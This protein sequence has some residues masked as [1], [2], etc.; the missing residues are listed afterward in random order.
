MQQREDRRAWRPV[1]IVKPA[2]TTARCKAK[3]SPRELVSHFRYN[4]GVP[5]LA[6]TSLLI[7]LFAGIVV[8][9]AT[10]PIL[11]LIAVGYWMVAAGL[12]A[13]VPGG[14]GYHVWMYRGLKNMNVGAWWW[15]PGAGPAI[16]E[17]H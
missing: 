13:G 17:A 10:V 15:S 9:T 6:L 2:L 11:T 5:E 4:V 12:I 14:V 16:P 8:A 1:S 7:A 3:L